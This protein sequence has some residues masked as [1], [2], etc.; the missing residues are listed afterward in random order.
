ML[1]CSVLSRWSLGSG[2]SCRLSHPPLV[3]KPP[4]LCFH[5]NGIIVLRI[6]SV[7]PCTILRTKYRREP[8]LISV[9]VRTGFPSDHVKQFVQAL[10]INLWARPI[11]DSVEAGNDRPAE[12]GDRDERERQRPENLAPP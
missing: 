9:I 3:F 7:E 5:P 12:I 10:G 2:P 4:V 11:P 8:R 1:G 6:L